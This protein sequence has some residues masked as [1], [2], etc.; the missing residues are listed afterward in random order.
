[1]NKQRRKTKVDE[2][3]EELAYDLDL[4]QKLVKEIVR[5]SLKEVVSSIVLRKQHVLLRGFAKFVTKGIS[6][7][8]KQ[9]FDPMQYETRNEEDW[10]KSKSNE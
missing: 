5:E 9:I 7:N 10:T 8:K 2:I 1:M 6:S 3:C 4:D